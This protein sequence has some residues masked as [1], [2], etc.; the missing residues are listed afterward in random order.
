MRVISKKPL[1]G[2]WEKHADAQQ[3]LL[4][5][6]REAEDADWDSPATVKAKYANASILGGNR[7]VFNIKGNSYRLV[8]RINYPYRVV[9]VRFV[10][11]HA[12]YDAIN[13]EEV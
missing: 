9:F 11:T 2:F 6:Y 3:P 8:V 1:R 7:V 4:A 13:A 12:E 5:W 10:G